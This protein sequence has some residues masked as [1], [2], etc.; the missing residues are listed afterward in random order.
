MRLLLECRFVERNKVNGDGLTFLDIL[1]NL[2]NAG[3]WDLDLEQVVLKTRCKE[4]ASIPKPKAVSEFF[5]SPLDF[6]TFNST[7]TNRLRTNTSEEARGAFLIVFTLIITAT[8]QTA[9]QPPG[10]GLLS[11][12][13][14]YKKNAHA[15]LLIK[16]GFF[17]LL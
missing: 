13:P 2:E 1:G 16:D 14:H 6:S 15:D 9:L 17:I 8:Y 3:V 4:A 5:K 11:K 10:G 12:D 7:I